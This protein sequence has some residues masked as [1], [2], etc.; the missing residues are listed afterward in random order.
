MSYEIKTDPDVIKKTSGEVVKKEFEFAGDDL[1]T[2]E[3]IASITSITADTPV[4][5]AALTIGGSPTFSG[6][7]VQCTLSGGTP[8]FTYKLTCRAVTTASQTLEQSGFLF[9]GNP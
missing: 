6:T 8:G 1:A 5:A 7:V 4:G 3:T 9:V 2:G